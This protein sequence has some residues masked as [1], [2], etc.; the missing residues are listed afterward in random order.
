VTTLLV[1]RGL[2]G[3]HVERRLDRRGHDVRTVRVPWSD[4]AAA[5]RTL[6]RAADEAG[7]AD[8]AWRLVWCAGSGVVASR[9]DRLEREVAQF[10]DLCAGLRAAP[11]TVFLASSAGGLYGGSPDSAPYSESSAVGP[12]S[13]YGRAKLAMEQV[14]AALAE[15]GTRVLVG[16]LANLYGPGQDLGKPQGLVSQICLAQLQR[17]PMGIY[18]SLDTLRDY[19]FVEDAA[20]MVVASVDRMAATAPGTV[21][22]KVLGSG[23]SVSV[24]MVVQEA[25]RAFRRRCPVVQRAADDAGQGRDLRLRSEVWADLD[26]LA[27]TP[28][29]LGLRLT[30][31]SVA[32]GSRAGGHDRVTVA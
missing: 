19:L 12:V 14:A 2:L 7:E 32:A 31:E 24:G 27:R 16:R 3:S 21:I 1:G 17:R 11:H 9:E 30:L 28:L 13:A 26:S 25:N 15:R 10:A 22:V 5:A 29:S 8:P 4:P 23:R 6:A 20:D 18:V